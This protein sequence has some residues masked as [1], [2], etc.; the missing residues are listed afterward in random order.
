M[1][2]TSECLECEKSGE[3]YCTKECDGWPEEHSFEKSITIV[4]IDDRESRLAGQCGVNIA[5]GSFPLTWPQARDLVL[6]LDHGLTGGIIY[7]K[8]ENRLRALRN[9]L[10]WAFGP[11]A[12]SKYR[13]YTKPF[14]PTPEDA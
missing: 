9:S 13:M 1:D 10:L 2:K 11:E 3:Y 4:H 6:A 12:E 8:N 5:S 7:K 14:T